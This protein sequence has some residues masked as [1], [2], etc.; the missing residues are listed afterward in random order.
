[1]IGDAIAG[2]SLDVVATEIPQGDP[3]IDASGMSRDNGRHRRT[4]LRV[5][6]GGCL[7]QLVP[8]PRIDLGEERRWRPLGRQVDG[9]LRHARNLPMHDGSSEGG[10]SM[11]DNA[12]EY[13]CTTLIAFARE[14]P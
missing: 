7:Q 9:V 2:V 1:V 10:T 12:P 4:P 5:R 11:V 13:R 14:L 3:R 6:D 8:D